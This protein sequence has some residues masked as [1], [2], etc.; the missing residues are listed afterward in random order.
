MAGEARIGSFIVPEPSLALR[1]VHP[2][3]ALTGGVLTSP[4]FS[5]GNWPQQP[6]WIVRASFIPS[7]YT[8]D[9]VTAKGEPLYSGSSELSDASK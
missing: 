2:R 6:S 3:E 5:L 8:L 7:P 1:T 4:S 9:E